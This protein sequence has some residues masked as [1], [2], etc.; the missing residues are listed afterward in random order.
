MI[1]PDDV[2]SPYLHGQY[3]LPGLGAAA[4]GFSF[5]RA[6]LRAANAARR[7]EKAKRVKR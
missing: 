1:N 5:L 7:A 6:Y 2:Q 3:L 4:L